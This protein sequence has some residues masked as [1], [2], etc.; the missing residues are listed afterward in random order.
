MNDCRIWLIVIA[1]LF[2]SYVVVPSATETTGAYQITEWESRSIATIELDGD[3]LYH[4]FNNPDDALAILT[5]EEELLV[6]WRSNWDSK[7]YEDRELFAITEQAE[8]R[9]G[10]HKI[11]LERVGLILERLNSLV[12]E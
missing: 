6:A 1:L 12:L 4:N 10:K 8:L 5:K 7:D 11:P 9:L 3:F 2:I